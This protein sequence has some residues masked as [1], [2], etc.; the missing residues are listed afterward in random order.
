MSNASV[1]AANLDRLMTMQGMRNA[2][3][4]QTV[5]VSRQI[6]SQW[7]QGLTMPSSQEREELIATALGCKPRDLYAEIIQET[8]PMLPISQWAKREGIPVGRAKSLF[9]LGI[10]EGHIGGAVG[11]MYLVPYMAHAPANSKKIVREARRPQWIAAFSVNLD[12][13]MRETGMSNSSMGLFTGVG[14]WAVVN[15]RSGRGYPLTDRLELIAQR[16]G[17]TL[18]ALLR[19]PTPEQIML[20]NIRYKRT[21]DIDVAFSVNLDALMRRDEVSNPALAADIRVAESTVAHWRNG[22]GGFPIEQL[23]LIAT[24]FG[25]NI[26]QLLSAPSDQQIKEWAFR[27]QLTD[28]D[29]KKRD[30]AAA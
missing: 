30:R 22:R 10:L 8:P 5:G 28:Q 26:K 24:K 16:L 13:L 29:N 19:E 18:E 20:W 4:A 23:H 25:L 14:T 15:W 9:D 3:L 6:V 27:Y 21:A 12:L 1:F 7:R 17:C 11:E 2:A